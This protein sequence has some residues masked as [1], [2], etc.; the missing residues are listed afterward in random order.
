[1]NES[2]NRVAVPTPHLEPL[3][4]N[5]SV[6]AKET[7]RFNSPVHIHVTSY[8]KYRHDPDNISLKAVLDGI[9]E[10]GL[11]SGDT[12]KQ[13]KTITFESCK[14]KDERTIIE[15]TDE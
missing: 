5:E 7:P 2:D 13:I 1:M 9:V 12:S 8:R 10:I 3:A 15:I 11:L 14:S 4:G 6:A